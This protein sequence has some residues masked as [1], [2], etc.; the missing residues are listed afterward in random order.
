MKNLTKVLLGATMLRMAA[1][2]GYNF[3]KATSDREKNEGVVT[4]AAVEKAKE[5]LNKEKLDR[6]ARIV[7]DRIREAENEVANAEKNGIFASKN[8][9]IMKV[10]SEKMSAAKKEFETTGDYKK[11]DEMSQKI[12]E[13]KDSAV[14]EAKLAVFGDRY[15]SIYL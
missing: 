11:W 7:K 13:E 3:E 8:R 15:R 4:N 12:R 6:E 1:E 9:N 2:E 14:Q 5:E 10:F